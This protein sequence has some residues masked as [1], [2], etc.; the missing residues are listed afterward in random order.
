[1]GPKSIE[2]YSPLLNDQ[3]NDDWKKFMEFKEYLSIIFMDYPSNQ[4][5]ELIINENI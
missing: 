4:I 1:M 5:I 2:G 3:L